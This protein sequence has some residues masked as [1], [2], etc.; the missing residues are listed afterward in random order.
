MQK[1]DFTVCT[2][3]P[4][5]NFRVERR[6]LIAKKKAKLQIWIERCRVDTFR[7]RLH[8]LELL[9]GVPLTFLGP[10]FV[11]VAVPSMALDASVRSCSFFASLLQAAIV[12]L[13]GL[14]SQS[15]NVYYIT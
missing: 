15:F 8:L 12:A 1:L 3:L 2:F 9:Y 11:F 7:S 13:L 5:V 14:L 6:Y 4:Y 10:P